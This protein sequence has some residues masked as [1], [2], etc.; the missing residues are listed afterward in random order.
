[1][2][3]IHKNRKTI[4]IFIS[5]LFFCSGELLVAAMGR[6]NKVQS[7]NN[8]I[9]TLTTISND[10]ALSQIDRSAVAR[11]ASVI[12]HIEQTFDQQGRNNPVQINEQ[13]PDAD[14]LKG[15][16]EI[17]AYCV[18]DSVVILFLDAE[19]KQCRYVKKTYFD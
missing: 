18:D 10:G 9:C 3:N 17:R 5:V 6:N 19:T 8:F 13:F 12:A 15:K 7:S 2:L 11:Y 16:R 14:V 4:S 1:M